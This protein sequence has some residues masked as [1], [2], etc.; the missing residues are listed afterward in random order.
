VYPKEA[1]REGFEVAGFEDEGEGPDGDDDADVGQGGDLGDDGSKA[2]TPSQKSAGDTEEQVAAYLRRWNVVA[3]ARNAAIWA[4]AYGNACVWLGSFT[5]DPAQPFAM[6]EKID[7]LRIVDRRFLQPRPWSLD[8]LGKPTL[9]DVIPHEGRGMIGPIHVSR[10]VMFPGANTD[11]QTHQANGYW[12]D[13][14]LQ[15]PYE[16]LQ[17][18][19]IVWRSAQQLISEASLGVLKIKGLYSALTGPAREQITNRLALFN[20]TRSIARNLTLDLDAEDYKRDSIS[21]AGVSDLTREAALRVAS[22]AEIPISVL[23]SDEPSGLNATGDA[24]IR[25]WLMRVH[26]YRTGE[27]E[28][29]TLYLVKALLAQ[30]GIAGVT[31]DKVE[32]L[33]I[34]WPNLWTPSATEQADIY[35]KTSGAD[36]TYF[37]MGVL[38]TAAI[39]K[40]RFGEDGY[41]QETQ[42]DRD[43]FTEPTEAELLAAAEGATGATGPTG[44]AAP[45]AVPGEG[46]S[47]E[48]V[49]AQVLN[50]AQVTS[51]V[52]IV[53]RVANE[54]I[55]R[56]AG[57]EIVMLAF[58]VD[59]PKAEALM[60]TAGKGFKPKEEPAPAPF[61][62]KLG[63]PP[64]KPGEAP[65]ENADKPTPPP[66]PGT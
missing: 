25:W 29:P 17:S 9:Y 27:L 23:L 50:G 38:S 57:V 53:A 19:G 8:A 21:F 10:L 40:S 47:G 45:V 36:Q 12:D 44:E 33:A 49:Q 24:S 65:P 56:D 55:P 15:R 11:A 4:R 58:Q 14:I 54:E 63:A 26:A 35:S 42:I 18:D 5:A 51:L 2:A 3:V 46:P 59:K 1:Y 6:G 41:S 48:N 22:A 39:A 43:A 34:K 60:G 37:D 61:G 20:A 28:T 52:D 62:A 13:S 31:A 32:R 66:K 64:P 7:F 16:A 30:S